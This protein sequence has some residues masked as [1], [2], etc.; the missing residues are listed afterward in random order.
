M[1][2][3]ATA[4]GLTS[5]TVMHIL[6]RNGVKK[7]TKG[8]L[9]PLNQAHIVQQYATGKSARQIAAI[10][11]VSRSTIDNILNRKNV[12]RHKRYSNTRLNSNFF[13]IIDTPAKAYFLG[14]LITDGSVGS[15]DNSVRLCLHKRDVQIL[16]LFSKEVCS[17]NT[18]YLRRDKPHITFSVK[19]AKWK[20]DL[21]Q[22]GVVPRKTYITKFPT[23][24]Q[25]LMPHLIRGMIDGD[26]WISCTANKH[27]IGFCG[28][29]Q[30]VKG[31]RDYICEHLNAFK[32]CI[33]QVK[34]HL[35]QIVWCSKR[36]IHEICTYLYRDKAEYFLPRKYQA[37]QRFES[38]YYTNDNTEVTA[39]IAKG[40]AA[41]QSVEGE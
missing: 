40:C 5:A 35:W 21:A 19:D 2:K 34:Q 13:Q 3:I 8:G 4:V 39:Q 26:G 41:P 16:Q 29:F 27:A 17:Q 38:L 33:K 20:K 25:S 11:N 23:I 37:F 15:M 9:Q 6:Q 1:H 18:L 14:M 10:H 31:L 12:D 36:D 24:A 7:R 32:V 28:N 22:Y 30:A